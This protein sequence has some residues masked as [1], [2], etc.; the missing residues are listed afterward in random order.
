[1]LVF[2]GRGTIVA[3]FSHSGMNARDSDDGDEDLSE[4][5]GQLVGTLS[6][7]PPCHAI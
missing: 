2:V 6:E 7:D 5:Q 1:M 4:D 3:G